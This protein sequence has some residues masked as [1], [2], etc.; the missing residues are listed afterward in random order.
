MLL[1]DLTEPVGKKNQEWFVNAVVEFDTSFASPGIDD[2]SP[3]PSRIRWGESGEKGGGR[4]SSTSTFFCTTER[5]FKEEGL[6]IPH[7]RLH[8]RKFVLVP[9]R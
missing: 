9:L 4:G 7:P 5:S 2:V 8:A 3:P 6:E 1:F